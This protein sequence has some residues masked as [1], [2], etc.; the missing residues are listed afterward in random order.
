[1][2]LSELHTIT[3]E[4]DMITM[5]A[6]DTYELLS[7][8][9]KVQGKW[10]VCVWLGYDGDETPGS[11]EYRVER[12]L[13]LWREYWDTIADVAITAIN[14]GVVVFL[15]DTEE[16]MRTAYDKVRGHD[17]VP[18][19]HTPGDFYACTFNPNGEILTENT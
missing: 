19:D 12:D 15:S 14:V 13:L 16:E 7:A 8:Y 4:I 18:G 1:M 5:K 11:F 10:A 2:V 3:G 9:C 17:G 6:P